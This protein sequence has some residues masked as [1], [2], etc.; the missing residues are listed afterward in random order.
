LQLQPFEQQRLVQDFAR[1]FADSP[2]RL[3]TLERRDLLLAGPPLQA[4][5]MDP[6]RLLGSDPSTGLP[7]GA[8]A[9]TLKRVASEIELWLH[10]HPLNL[11]RQRRGELAVTALWVWG[12]LPVREAA[13]GDSAPTRRLTAAAGA[14]LP[15]LLGEDTYV[16]ALWRLRAG[17][18]AASAE[19]LPM[20]SLD[21]EAA[22]AGTGGAVLLQRVCEPPGLLAT[23]EQLEHRCWPAAR[24]ALRE[25]RLSA[26]HL[27]TG[28][29]VHSLSWWSL[30]RLWRGRRPWWE[31][32]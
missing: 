23:L 20:D 1:V 10:E 7:H 2:W 17:S 31:R 14:A 16:E 8:D 24:A 15:R 29:R 4:S 25:R 32:L 28:E 5:G 11:E 13:V 18:R 19:R 30:A 3:L 26:L 22:I 6:A 21:V 12:A 9:A 27:L